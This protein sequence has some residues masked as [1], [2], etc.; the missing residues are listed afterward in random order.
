MSIIVS[1]ALATICFTYKGTEECNPVLLGKNNTTPTGEYTLSLRATNV[2]GYG[3]NIL[4]FHETANDVYAI[5]RVWMLSPKQQR[6]QRLQSENVNDRY[7]SGG[8]IN[9]DPAVYDKL[10]DCCSTDTLIIK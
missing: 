2:Y 3:G 10:V 8:C 7:I 5:H 4:Q 6:M 1:I 9:V